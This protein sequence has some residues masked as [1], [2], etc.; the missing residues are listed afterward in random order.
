MKSIGHCFA[1][2][3]H[4]PTVLQAEIFSVAS[5]APKMVVKSLYWSLLGQTHRMCFPFEL[6]SWVISMAAVGGLCSGGCGLWLSAFTLTLSLISRAL[7]SLWMTF[8]RSVISQVS[9]VVFLAIWT[10][11]S[12]GISPL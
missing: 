5:W 1:G 3:F 2:P 10:L 7:T 6:V 8:R 12:C 4:S 11:T 9:C